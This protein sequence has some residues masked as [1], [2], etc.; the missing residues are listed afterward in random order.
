MPHGKH[1]S[2]T[3][4]SRAKI[5]KDTYWEITCYLGMFDVQAVNEASGIIFG[6]FGVWLGI[7]DKFKG[8]CV[9]SGMDILVDVD[10]KRIGVLGTAIFLQQPHIIHGDVAGIVGPQ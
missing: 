6:F 7:T 1:D 5:R 10:K 4:R 2:S 9:V 8:D 3:H